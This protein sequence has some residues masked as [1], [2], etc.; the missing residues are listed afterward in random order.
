ME[1]I[2][3]RKAFLKMRYFILQ[4]QD[5]ISGFGKSKIVTKKDKTKEIW[6]EDIIILDQTSSGSLTEMEPSAIAKFIYDKTKAG[7]DLKDWNIWWHS[8]ATFRAFW[9]PTDDA[10]IAAHAGGGSHLISIVSNHANE[11]EARLDIFPKDTSPFNKPSA[12]K[13]DLDLFIEEAKPSK[14]KIA[15]I[16]NLD[17]LIDDCDS[18][19]EGLESMKSKAEDEKEIEEQIEEEDDDLKKECKTEMDLKVKKPIINIPKWGKA[20]REKYLSKKDQKKQP[21]WNWIDDAWG[22][23]KEEI[24]RDKADDFKQATLNILT[25]EEEEE[26]REYDESK[27]YNGD[28]PL[29]KGNWTEEDEKEFNQDGIVL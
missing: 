9:S 27:E 29:I 21:K 13:H 20:N 4:T 16:A 3:S 5:E 10:T 18:K 2:L 24:K 15:K 12:V 1:I 28:V 11:Y 8:H 14:A 19:I 17:K 26:L 23:R 7:E 22:D 25:K 6:V